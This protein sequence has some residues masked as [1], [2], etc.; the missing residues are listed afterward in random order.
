MA[1][2]K[3]SAPSREPKKVYPPPRLAPLPSAKE[4]APIGKFTKRVYISAHRL[5]PIDEDDG[6]F[7]RRVD[8]PAPRQAAKRVES[9][10]L[11]QFFPSS[12]KGDTSPPPA[13]KAPASRNLPA[14]AKV[15]PAAPAARAKPV[16][17]KPGAAPK[18]K[19]A[20]TKTKPAVD[21]S[22][23][24]GT[25]RKLD[26]DAVNHQPPRKSQRVAEQTAPGLFVPATSK[27][28]LELQEREA[29]V[30]AR[31]KAVSDFAVD[32]ENIREKFFWAGQALSKAFS[33]KSETF[34][35]QSIPI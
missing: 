23:N 25:K 10:G 31:E 7:R 32:L 2:Q 30:S 5:P 24:S 1:P 34:P 14:A 28:E 22:A 16:V 13:R 35:Q 11:D 27:R 17:T 12:P 3:N 9:F 18:T 8:V 20:A 15:A 29:A 19:P 21:T 4:D 26:G 6:V 33:S